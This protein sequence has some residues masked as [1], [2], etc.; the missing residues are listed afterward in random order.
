MSRNKKVETKEIPNPNGTVPT[1]TMSGAGMEVLGP[2]DLIIPRLTLVQPTS[3][4]DGVEAGKF[5]MNLTAEQFDQ[6]EAVFLKV[7]KGRVYFADDAIERK[8]VCG[9]SDRIKPSPRFE[10]P[11]SPTC[12]ECL[13]SRWNGKEPPFCNES[14]NLL[15]VMVETELPFWWSVKS[16]AIAPTK[17]FVSAIALRAR[18]GKNLFDAKAT[19]KSQLVTLPGKKYH[20]PV[21][22]LTWLKDSSAYRDLYNHYAHEEVERTFMAEE[23]TNGDGADREDFDWKTGEQVK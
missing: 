7:T 11:A 17:R 13:F 4:I 23:A 3:Q 21:Y 5:Y 1:V 10:T 18:M 12:K 22:I 6:V 8:P 20:V 15:G 19:I 9:S 2:E 14:Y 16:T